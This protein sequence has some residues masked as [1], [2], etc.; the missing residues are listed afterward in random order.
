M[1]K[2]I[3]I[4]SF[5]S[6]ICLS[7][8]PHQIGATRIIA[9]APQAS[10]TPIGI[11]LIQKICQQSPAKDVCISSL[12]SDPN[13]LKEDLKGLTMIAIRVASR[14]ATDISGHVKVLLDDDSME[15]AV[16]QGLN[17]CMESYLDATQQLDD[18][19]VALLENST[20]G[21]R[22]RLDAAIA[23]ADTC[24]DSLKG[25]E[26]LLR[27][28]NLVFRQLCSNVLLFNKAMSPQSALST[29]A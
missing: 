5:L 15:P 12:K 24:D 6:V 17:D 18:S 21:I 29:G 28:K 1:M 3:T 14:N 23:A 4:F 20:K 27:Q 8:V 22:A 13:S 11:D 25:N 26:K 2:P 16:Q 19:V 7:F 10:S 9:L